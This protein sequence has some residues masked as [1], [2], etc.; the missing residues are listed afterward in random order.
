MESVTSSASFA[1]RPATRRLLHALLVA[2]AASGSACA[3]VAHGGKQTIRVSTE[4]PGAT[5]FVNGEDRGRTPTQVNLR[6]K[7][8]S[9]VVRLERAGYAP[10][11][12]EVTRRASGWIAADAAVGA[13]QFLNQG[14]SGVQEQAASA[15][16]VT[17]VLVGIDLAAG[18]AYALR[19]S[20]IHVVLEKR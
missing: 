2:L 9:T 15:A 7:A 13:A 19:P 11:T 5:V 6:R 20:S 10:A 14:L 1:G 18:G 8:R 12:V 17:A 4:P 16:A 3:T